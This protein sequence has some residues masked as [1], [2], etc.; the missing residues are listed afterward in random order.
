M[1]DKPGIFEALWSSPLGRETSWRFLKKNWDFF[2]KN[3]G[4]GGHILQR[5]I[6][7]A[8]SFATVK[9]AQDIKSFFKTHKAFSA[10][11]AV[12]QAIERV[13]SNADWLRRDFKHLENWL[14]RQS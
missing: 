7:P 8:G 2:S 6:S 11:R 10:E 3:Y 1:Q 9:H 4:Q 13:N 5:I 12:E 14:L